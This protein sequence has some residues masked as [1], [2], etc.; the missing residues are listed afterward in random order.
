MQTELFTCDINIAARQRVKA[1][2]SKHLAG[3]VS[4]SSCHWSISL[5]C[6]GLFGHFSWT[7][8]RDFQPEGSLCSA[9][10]TTSMLGGEIKGYAIGN[11]L[12]RHQMSGGG[13]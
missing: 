8:R 6:P 11:H 2:D 1:I 7:S 10:T 13:A 4:N 12:Q 3:W 5:T 9:C